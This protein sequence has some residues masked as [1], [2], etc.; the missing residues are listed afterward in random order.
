[1]ALPVRAVFFDV[2]FTLIAPGPMF[3]A[4]GYRGFSERHGMT[5][6]ESRFQPAVAAAAPL[7]EGPEDA[8]YD[9]ASFV[10]YARRVLE[11]MGARGP[12]L[13]ACAREIVDEWARCHHFELYDEVPAVFRQLAQEGFRIGLISNTN[14]SLASFESHFD[15][16]GLIAGAVSSADHGF[17]K[18]HRSIFAAAL[19]LVGAEAADAVM[20]GDSVPH[21]VE[22]ALRV[23]MR[24]VLLHRGHAGHPRADELSERGVP[25]IRSLTEL[26]ALLAAWRAG[27]L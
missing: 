1:M 4:E 11:L 27:A 20:V 17:M 26:P 3:Q 18:P 6:D 22:G 8:P 12:R 21:D 25:I 5:V 24:A 14:R 16:H 15:L 13:E 7:L 19:Q 23:G 2:D 10:A 9:E